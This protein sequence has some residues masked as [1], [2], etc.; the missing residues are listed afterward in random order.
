MPP[1]FFMFQV[2]S[3]LSK[4]EDEKYAGFLVDH[5]TFVTASL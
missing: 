2:T 4:E 3:F 5:S 1:I